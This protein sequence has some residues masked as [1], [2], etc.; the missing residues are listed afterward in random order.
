MLSFRTGQHHTEI[1]CV[2]KTGL[3]NPAPV[4]DQFLMHDR[5]LSGRTAKADKTQLH[6]EPERLLQG[7]RLG[8]NV[9]LCQR[10]QL[11]FVHHG[12][13]SFQTSLTDRQTANRPL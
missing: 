3:G 11:R 9:F 10:Q 2:E 1:E 8:L 5:N 4:L 7:D 13:T 12:R 6:P